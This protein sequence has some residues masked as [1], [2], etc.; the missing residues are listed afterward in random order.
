MQSVACILAAMTPCCRLYGMIGLELAAAYPNVQ[1]LYKDWIT[2]YSSHA[3]LSVPDA[4]EALLDEVGACSEYGALD[5]RFQAEKVILVETGLAF[6]C[7][8]RRV[9]KRA[10]AQGGCSPLQAILSEFCVGPAAMSLRSKWLSSSRVH[11]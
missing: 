11:R 2:T 6:A 1:H 4:Q 3:Y 8:N 10:F 9:L 5:L 7:R